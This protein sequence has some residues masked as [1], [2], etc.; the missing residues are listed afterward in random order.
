MCWEAARTRIP[1]TRERRLTQR[2]NLGC[3]ASH[4]GGGGGGGSMKTPRPTMSLIHDSVVIED[5]VY[6]VDSW[7]KSFFYSPKQC[8]WGR[9]NHD[10]KP[11]NKRDWCMIDNLLYSCGQGGCKYL[12]EP[13][14]LDRCDA[15]GMNWTGVRSF[16]LQRLKYRFYHSRVVHFGGKMSRVWQS[17]QDLLLG[18]KLTNFALNI[19]V[20]W[21]V[22]VGGRGH[23]TLQIWCYKISLCKRVDNIWGANNI[24]GT[25]ECS[26]VVFTFY[27]LL[28]IAKVL[29]YISVDV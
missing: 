10:S 11:K 4:G 14:E 12:C 2:R 20:F 24:W 1:P 15:E 28:S 29:Y 16:D 22:L 27:S 18:A 8:K 6:V 17:A 21:N 3:P 25:V 5:K 9:G 13:H 7:N 23:Q 26:N 19:V